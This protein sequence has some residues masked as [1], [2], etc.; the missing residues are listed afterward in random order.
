MEGKNAEAARRGNAEAVDE[1]EPESGAQ[2][3]ARHVAVACS[4]WHGGALCNKTAKWQ[5]A[6]VRL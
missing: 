1:A 6:F 2:A 5:R 4:A 3:L